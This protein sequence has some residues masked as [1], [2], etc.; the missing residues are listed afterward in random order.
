MA[1]AMLKGVF[2]KG[3]SSSSSQDLVFVSQLVKQSHVSDDVLMET[4]RLLLPTLAEC[5]LLSIT[6]ALCCEQ[7][8]LS[9]S[10]EQE[11]SE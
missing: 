11:H 9:A 3:H 8:P 4:L 1:S 10:A 2:T 7:L 5:E 6:E